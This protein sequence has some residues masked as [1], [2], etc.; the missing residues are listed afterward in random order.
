MRPQSFRHMK[1][2]IVATLNDPTLALQFLSPDNQSRV[3]YKV[4]GHKRF[5]GVDTVGLSFQE[6]K[7]RDADYIIKTRGKAAGSGRLWIDPATGRIHQTELS[8]QSA[9]ETARITV[10]YARDS[11]LDL[12]LP[13]RDGGH[14]PI[15]RGVNRAS[16]VWV[17]APAITCGRSSS[18]GRPTPT[19]G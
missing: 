6:P 5:D 12:W 4:D 10:G 13:K 19:R 14:L 9:T 16:A 3:T 8:M 11:A 1:A 2:E 15:E 18:A 7:N 17:P